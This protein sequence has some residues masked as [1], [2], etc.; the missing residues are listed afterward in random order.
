MDFMGLIVLLILVTLIYRA[1]LRS[2]AMKNALSG[3]LNLVQCPKCFNEVKK[4]SE[5]CHRCNLELSLCPKCSNVIWK[6][7]SIC[8]FCMS[9]LETC[10]NCKKLCITKNKVCIHCNSDL[11]KAI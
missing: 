2:N 8:K 9:H 6:Q 5:T 10:P 11:P 1:Y 3:K 7:A 4:E